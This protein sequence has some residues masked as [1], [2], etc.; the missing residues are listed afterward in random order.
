M[1]DDVVGE[2]GHGENHLVHDVFILLV[3]LVHLL[4]VGRQVRVH[5]T[6]RRVVEVKVHAYSSFVALIHHNNNVKVN[7]VV[8]VV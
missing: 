2:V 6:Q 1:V 5:K 4:Q 7:T 3:S 8:E